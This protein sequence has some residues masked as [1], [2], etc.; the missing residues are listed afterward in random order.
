MTGLPGPIPRLA[1]F[2][3]NSTMCHWTAAKHILRYLKG[4]KDIGITYSKPESN[5]VTSQNDFTRYSNASFTN[6]YDHTSVS[7]YAFT[8]AGGAITWGSK[9]QNVVSLSTTEAGYICLSDAVHE[10]TWLC[11][12]YAEI[13]YPQKEPTLVY[14]DNLDAL[15]IT[16]NM[17]YHKRTKHFDIKHHYIH[18]QISNKTIVTEYLPMAQITADILTKALPKKAHDIHMKSLGMSST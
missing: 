9:K 16:E 7:G 6:N 12:L 4:T 14:G 2:M 15:A 8:S 11:N 3:A 5:N 10:A 18:E 13:G 1:S 17:H